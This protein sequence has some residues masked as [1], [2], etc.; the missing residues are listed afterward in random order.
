MSAVV[1]ARLPS[2]R[3]SV[4]QSTRQQISQV[5]ARMI[6]RLRDVVVSAARFG[7]IVGSLRETSLGILIRPVWANFCYGSASPVVLHRRGR[8]LIPDSCR[9]GRMSGTEA[10]GRCLKCPSG[11]FRR[12]ATIE[13]AD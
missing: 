1:L 11:I 7:V 10:L 5:L 2:L 12:L 6:V 4:C 8:R 13:I 3:S 9:V